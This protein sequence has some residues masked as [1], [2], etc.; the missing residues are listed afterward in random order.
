MKRMMSFCTKD[1]VLTSAQFGFRPKMSCVQAIV[2]VT[3]YLR[4]QIDNKMPGQAC[5]IDLKI[6]FDTLNHEILLH[7]LKNYGFRGKINEILG[8]FLKDR[9]QYVRLNEIETEKLT[10]QT[11]VPQGSLLGPFLFLIYINDLPE[12][13]EKAE[14]AMF[15]DDTTLIESGKRG[16]PQLS[17]EINC[18]QY[19]FSSN[20]LTI[21]EKGEAMGFGYGK[22]D[23][24]KIGVSELNYKASCRYL[25]I[26]LDKKRLFREHIEYVVKY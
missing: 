24:I 25:G 4:E 21:C 11:G 5:F 22:P 1:K 19:R 8:S 26:H 14:V 17:Q 20:K 3:E 15:A 18:V 6:A 10:V 16:D 13:C 7:K 2:K 12:S 9:Q 23:T